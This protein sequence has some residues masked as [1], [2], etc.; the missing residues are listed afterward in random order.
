MPISIDAGSTKRRC[1]QILLNIRSLP[2]TEGGEVSEAWGIVIMSVPKG[3]SNRCL[4]ACIIASEDGAPHISWSV[5]ANFF[6]FRFYGADS[7]HQEGAVGSWIMAAPWASR[8]WV[9]FNVDPNGF[10]KCSWDMGNHLISLSGGIFAPAGEH[11]CISFESSWLDV[12]EAFD[13][14]GINSSKRTVSTSHCEC[15][16]V[17]LHAS[18]ILH[19]EKL[20]NVDS[21]HAGAGADQAEY[22]Y[23]TSQIK[24]IFISKCSN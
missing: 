13:G 11:I 15:D 3:D 8:T 17:G 21:E 19:W 5:N 1:T 6:A 24:H 16:V 22:Q 14:M 2:S 9:G 23:K 7:L 20:R 4:S 18:V 10:V 12:G